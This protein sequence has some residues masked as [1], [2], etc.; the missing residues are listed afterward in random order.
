MQCL[1]NWGLRL[2]D[3]RM[4][5]AE[6]MYGITY[7]NL[8]DAQREEWAMV[9]QEMSFHLCETC[10]GRTGDFCYQIDTM[11]NSEVRRKHPMK[12][13]RDGWCNAW[14]SERVEPW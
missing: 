12:V 5:L 10:G 7:D 13:R 11:P 14:T 1:T 6:S 3:E 8:T 4:T 9:A 2:G